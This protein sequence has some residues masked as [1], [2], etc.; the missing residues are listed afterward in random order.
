MVSLPQGTRRWSASTCSTATVIG[1]PAL[2]NSRDS[3]RLK[4]SSHSLSHGRCDGEVG[5]ETVTDEISGAQKAVFGRSAPV[6][7]SSLY[8]S[9]PFL[10]PTNVAR[11]L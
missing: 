6:I 7:L 10:P 2:E 3:V 4:L 11:K 9:S 1:N 8:L 5:L